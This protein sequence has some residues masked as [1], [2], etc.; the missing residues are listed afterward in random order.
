MHTLNYTNMWRHYRAELVHQAHTPTKPLIRRWPWAINGRSGALAATLAA[1]VAVM[2]MGAL[3]SG[4]ELTRCEQA[5]LASALSEEQMGFE[6]F[7][8]LYS[9]DVCVVR[10]DQP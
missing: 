5:Y 10:K 3:S 9:G 2:V 4:V 8:E 7:S 1:T 6:E